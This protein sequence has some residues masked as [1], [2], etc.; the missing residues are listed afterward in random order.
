MPLPS[1][2][3]SYVAI[4]NGSSYILMPQKRLNYPDIAA[5]RYHDASRAMPTEY[6]YRSRFCD[7]SFFFVV[8]K[9]LIKFSI[10]PPIM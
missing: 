9:H 1:S 8:D 4:A 5:L 10:L 2:F 3:I 6:V 7:S